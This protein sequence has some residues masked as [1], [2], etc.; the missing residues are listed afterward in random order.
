MRRLF[1][2]WRMSYIRGLVKK[3]KGCVF[4]DKNEADDEQELVIA[5][6]KYVYVVMNKYP[7]SNGHLMVV[8]YEHIP[9]QETMSAEA[10]TD[11]MMMMNKAI[12]VLRKQ[13]YPSGFNIGANLGSTAGAGIA[14]HF[15]FHIVPRWESDVNFITVL[16]GTRI[17]PDTLENTH[18]ELKS[19]WKDLYEKEK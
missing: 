17:I 15:H 2:P 8:P 7:Y 3:D 4:C 9:T 5:R 13:C 14:E 11:L 6:S 1:T 18:K 19:I 16:G 10:L 12:A